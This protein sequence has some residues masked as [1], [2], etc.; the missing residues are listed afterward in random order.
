MPIQT[1]NRILLTGAGF[2]HNIG[3]PLARD[4]WALIF[5]QREIQLTARV[6]ELLRGNFDFELVYHQVVTGDYT[7]AE[8][9]A[10][11]NATKVAYEKLDSI[12]RNYSFVGVGG[13]SPQINMYKVRALINKFAGSDDLKGFIF[14]LNQDLF[15]ERQYTNGL[16]AR[17]FV[18]GV[19]QQQDWFT[20]NFTYPLTDEHFRSLPAAAALE[21]QKE[22]L[23]EG[24][25]FFYI[26][27]HG[28]VNWVTSDGSNSLVVGYHKTEQIG[29]EPL[30]SWYFGIFN[31]VLMH[32]GRQLLIIGYGFNDEH[33]N[34]MLRDAVRD[35][36]LTLHIINRATPDRFMK[37]INDKPYG[38]EI[39]EGI[40]GY[41]PYT[42]EQLFPQNRA[43]TMEC[44]LLC[45][46]YFDGEPL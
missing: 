7:D 43:D 29:N 12:V 6:Q 40:C 30:L 41:F 25:N 24:G 3:A 4:M 28:S 1:Q 19:D 22:A 9:Q 32:P 15:I 14:T 8:K 42:F 16:L 23:L 37:E 5:N 27:L 45:Q 2:T 31:D 11:K 20:G 10:I 39:A 38:K 13:P 35:H 33:I 18:P 21:D 26:K 36:N 17:P 46:N 44:G 34:A